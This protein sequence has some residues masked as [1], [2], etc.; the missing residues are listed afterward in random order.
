MALVF[1]FKLLLRASTFTN[2]LVCAVSIVLLST[3]RAQAPQVAPA[4]EVAPTPAPTQQLETVEVKSKVNGEE[5]YGLTR[6]VGQAEL[7]K[8]GDDNVLDVLKRQPNIT[9]VNGQISLR[10][11]ASSYVRVLVDGQRPPPGFSLDS[12]SPAQVER[13]EIM[14][15]SGVET[16]AQ[17]VGGTINIILKRANQKRQGQFSANVQHDRKNDQ[18]RF[19]VSYGDGDS[20][21][22]WLISASARKNMTIGDSMFFSERLEPSPL[23]PSD[24]ILTSQKLQQDKFTSNNHS[25]NFYPKLTFTPSSDTRWQLSVGAYTYRYG[26][27]FVSMRQQLVG[28]AG[29]IGDNAGFNRGGGNGTWQNHELNQALGEFGKLE[30]KIDRSGWTNRRDSTNR[31]ATTDIPLDRLSGAQ[32]DG[33]NTSVKAVIRRNFE[34]GKNLSVG[35]EFE[36]DRTQRTNFDRI[37]GVS[38]L[39]VAQL[40]TADKSSQRATFV[41]HEWQINPAWA[42]DLGLRFEALRLFI[43]AATP[44]ER[45]SRQVFIAPVLQFSYRPDGSK[46]QEWRAEIAR[47]WKPLGLNELSARNFRSVD[48]SFQSPDAIGN[49]DLRPEK[50]SAID[51]NHNR[52]LGSEGSMG[53]TLSYKTVDDVILERRTLIDGRWLSRS[54]NVGPGGTIGVELE[55]KFRLDDINSNWPKTQVR[56]SVGRYF[57][58]V[59]NLPAPGNRLGS[60]LPLTFNAGFDQKTAGSALSF[61]ASLRYSRQVLLRSS[62]FETSDKA[63]DRALDM[64]AAWAFTP[65]ISARLSIDGIGAKDGADQSQFDGPGYIERQISKVKSQPRFKANVEWRL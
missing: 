31:I 35:I 17:S 16:S 3:A 62:A 64:Y 39:P 55:A 56:A 12:L 8:Y 24:Y 9:I 59:N 61:G 6:I 46:T 10:G 43:D 21:W 47:K 32:S 27:D 45:I 42:T 60:Q 2:T 57:S 20:R 14:P 34:G 52:R 29:S 18:G 26:S 37:N 30:L 40:E 49:S 63:D 36:S 48:N 22:A 23:V 33:S 13:I 38:V 25:A 15:T 65:K 58:K 4:S 41:R 54:E 5:T 50:S 53:V 1:L 19:N 44:D 28:T 11:L 7:S 51:L